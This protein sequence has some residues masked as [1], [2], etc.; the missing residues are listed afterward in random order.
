MSSLKEEKANIHE[1]DSAYI[2]GMSLDFKP[3][4]LFKRILAVA[5]DLGIITSVMYAAFLILFMLVG[6]IMGVDFATGGGLKTVF[7]NE[8][9]AVIIIIV[10]VLLVMASLLATHGYF[11]YFEHK[12]SY[13]LGKKL[14]GLKVISTDGHAL[15]LAQCIKREIFRYVDM[16]LL[17]PGVISIILTE[18]NLRLGD[19]FS[20]TMVV[21]SEEEEQAENFLYIDKSDFEYLMEKLKPS[22]LDVDRSMKF[23]K[24]AHA[25]YIIKDDK[26]NFNKLMWVSL[27]RTKISN[28]TNMNI[29]DESLLLFFSEYIHQLSNKQ[30]KQ[31]DR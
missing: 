14:F 12:K 5:V 25:Y 9:G 17:F 30:S 20:N 27:F 19:I 2:Q 13:T 28:E 24:E 8:L 1:L 15:S 10:V 3:A 4:P 11:I 16:S 29:E 21:H 6:L 18:K 22:P 31:K 26:V 23:L 7:G